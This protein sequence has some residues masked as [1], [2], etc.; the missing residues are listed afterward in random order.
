M[1]AS[2]IEELKRRFEIIDARYRAEICAIN[3]EYDEI[4][5]QLWND[6]ETETVED[7]SLRLQNLPNVPHS[8]DRVHRQST[9][10]PLTPSNFEADSP[11][12]A[13]DGEF[14]LL[15]SLEI[16]HDGLDTGTSTKPTREKLQPTSYCHIPHSD[17]VSQ[18]VQ[19][20]K[21]DVIYRPFIP[22]R[23]CI[24]GIKPFDDAPQ[25][26]SEHIF[27]HDQKI[28]RALKELCDGHDRL[29]KNERLIKVHGELKD[30]EVADIS[31]NSIDCHGLFF[32]FI[33]F[34]FI[35]WYRKLIR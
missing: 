26:I 7:S 8:P 4:M 2:D 12:A 28:A 9:Q 6:E 15:C 34:F 20:T 3:A 21:N 32:I 11:G 13:I 30:R 10:V 1:D 19:D 31:G 24:C 18:I 14:S 5:N 29:W 33:F 25:T 22:E 27:A 17:Q 23:T 35:T 16:N